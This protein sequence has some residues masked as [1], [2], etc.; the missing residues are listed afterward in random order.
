MCCVWGYT[1]ACNVPGVYHVWC[2]LCLVCTVCGVYY[3][4]FV[5]CLVCTV[6]CLCCVWCAPYQVFTVSGV[7]CDWCVLC[8]VCVLSDVYAWYIFELRVWSVVYTGLYG[9][10]V[11]NVSRV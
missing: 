5:L 2:L 3:V 11:C 1:L 10:M 8:L 4:L 9:M 6:P 7:H